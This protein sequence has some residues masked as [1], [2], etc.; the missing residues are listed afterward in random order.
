M[1][2][3]P[4][5]MRF[6]PQVMDGPPPASTAGW[7]SERRPASQLRGGVGRGLGAKVALLGCSG[8]GVARSWVPGGGA[9]CS[10]AVVFSGREACGPPVPSPR[11]AHRLPPA[12]LSPWAS[13]CA[14]AGFPVT[15]IGPEGML[16]H[17]VRQSLS[18]PSASV[19]TKF[20]VHPGFKQ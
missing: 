4:S 5:S 14:R 16:P 2:N 11:G 15:E 1:R 8:A 20:S 12:S 18:A 17:L 19:T 9:R 6:S 3:P 10:G 13:C 7:R